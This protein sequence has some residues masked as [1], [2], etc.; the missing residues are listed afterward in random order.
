MLVQTQGKKGYVKTQVDIGLMSSK[1]K[2]TKG[3]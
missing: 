1:P 2:I 3:C